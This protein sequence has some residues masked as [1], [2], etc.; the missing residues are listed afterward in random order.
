MNTELVNG[1][2]LVFKVSDK[3]EIE[4]LNVEGEVVNFVADMLDVNSEVIHLIKNNLIKFGESIY[5]R[6]GSFVVVSKVSFDD[7]L[8]IVPTIQEA[9]DFIEMEE[10][11]RQLE[12]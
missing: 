3:G 7:D 1:N 9:F 2:T 8:N 5:K 10:I 4:D 11:E 6:K 12:L